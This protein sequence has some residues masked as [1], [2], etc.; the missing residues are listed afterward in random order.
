M[1]I[2]GILIG[3]LPATRKFEIDVDG[4]IFYGTIDDSVDSEILVKYVYKNVEVEAIESKNQKFV[5]VKF[6]PK[7]NK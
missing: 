7:D 4:T 2:N 3:V 6:D 5:L 1:K